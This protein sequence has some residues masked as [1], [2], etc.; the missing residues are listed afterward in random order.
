MIEA[1][2]FVESAAPAAKTSPNLHPK[3]Y[4]LPRFIVLHWS[5]GSPKPSAGRLY[6]L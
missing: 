5:T 6:Q 1:T 2:S 3:T 4:P